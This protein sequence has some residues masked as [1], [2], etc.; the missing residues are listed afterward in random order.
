M[1]L[2]VVA[3]LLKAFEKRREFLLLFQDC[4]FILGRCSLMLQYNIQILNAYYH[5]LEENPTLCIL[6]DDEEIKDIHNR[7][8]NFKNSDEES[9]KNEYVE[10]FRSMTKDENFKKVNHHFPFI[11]FN[12][13][14][15][16]PSESG[17]IER[18]TTYLNFFNEYCK[19]ILPK[20]KQKGGKSSYSNTKIKIPNTAKPGNTITFDV[21]L[22]N[23]AKLIVPNGAESG[24]T[25]NI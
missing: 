5:F 21:D 19:R 1:S 23:Q 25:I 8:E 2:L 11:M 24:N 13:E 22:A 10:Q 20:R 15:M 12:N 9:I 18:I 14:E 17:V 6:N 4:D 7:L 3:E 16:M